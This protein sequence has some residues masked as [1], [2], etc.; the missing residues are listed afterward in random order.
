MNR[1][2][3][4]S[5]R[6]SRDSKCRSSMIFYEEAVEYKNIA[7]QSAISKMMNT[8]QKAL[9]VSADQTSHIASAAEQMCLNAK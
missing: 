5:L 8:H 7:T 9:L 6:S 2:C 4:Q 1:T 3:L